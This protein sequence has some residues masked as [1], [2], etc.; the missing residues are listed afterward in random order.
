V[1]GWSVAGVVDDHVVVA[2]R[3]S[4]ARHAVDQ[5][6]RQ[7]LVRAASRQSWTRHVIWTLRTRRR[8]RPETSSLSA[9]GVGRCLGGSCE[10]SVEAILAA[11]AAHVDQSP[12]HH[13]VV[14]EDD[15]LDRLTAGTDG[16]TQHFRTHPE[17]RPFRVIA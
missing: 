17:I 2:R 9:G 6:I 15:V 4:L 5:Q 3:T 11:L 8:R 14:L 1:T 12:A 16:R 13:V 7:T 10:R